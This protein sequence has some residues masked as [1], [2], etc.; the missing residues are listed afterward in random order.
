MAQTAHH[1]PPCCIF[2]HHFVTLMAAFQLG[3]KRV[4]GDPES[5]ESIT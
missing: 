4:K 1:C 5:I 2:M 3:I